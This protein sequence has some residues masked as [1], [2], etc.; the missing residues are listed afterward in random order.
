MKSRLSACDT[1][2]I[3][4]AFERVKAIQN[5]VQRNRM[6]VFRMKNKRVVMAIGTAEIAVRKK[7]DRTDLPTPI[8][9]GGLQK[10]FDLSPHLSLLI[11]RDLQQ[12]G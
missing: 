1:N 12:V 5:V 6:K 11:E 7:E 4:P 9:K 8:Y 10:T 3:D 2:P